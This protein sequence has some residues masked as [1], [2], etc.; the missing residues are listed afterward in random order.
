MKKI[1]FICIGFVFICVLGLGF[2]KTQE[3]ALFDVNEILENSIFVEKKFEPDVEVVFNKEKDVEAYYL[4]DDSVSLVMVNFGFEKMG[5][6][7]EP[8]SGVGILMEALLL[9]G[10][11]RWSREELRDFMKEKGIKIGLD[12]GKDNF[13][14]AFS[15][16]KE[17]EKEAWEVLKA[18]LYDPRLDEEDIRVVKSQLKMMRIRAEENPKT[19]LDRLIAEEFFGEH[20]YGKFVYPSDEELDD[21][22]AD[23]IRSFLKEYMR[24]ENLT[25]GIAGNIEKND[26]ARFLE[27]MFGELKYETKVS[28][29]GE[30]EPDFDEVLKSVDIK[31]SKQSFVTHIGKGIRRSD[32]DFYPFYF[33]DFIFGGSGL[34]SRL[35]KAVREEEGLVYGIYSYMSENDAMALW[36]ISYSSMSDNVEKIEK[37][38]DD[39]YAKFVEYG[40]S[41]EEFE[42]AKSSLLSSFNLRFS[43]VG[44]ISYQLQMMKRE[45]L[46]SEFFKN[47]QDFVRSVTRE[48][49]N[50]VI[51]EKM[52]RKMRVFVG[53][54][55]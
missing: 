43:G 54:G 11:G 49:V 42:T 22:G 51:K 23:D 5:S 53:K 26:V 47:R 48:E 32:K 13:D 37:I 6:A 9:D 39:E 21:L 8:K 27:F 44:K 29:L 7:Y 36:T 38:I 35:N 19:K 34:N 17:F 16:V 50:K 2:F 15:Y 18:V 3:K 1:V 10:A 24:K 4:K 31:Q 41:V 12:V 20:P 28:K 25:I 46:G 40:V 45:G 30:F 52:P 14:V 33:A 55:E